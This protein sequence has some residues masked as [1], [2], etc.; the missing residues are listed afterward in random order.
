MGEG[1][2]TEPL[3]EPATVVT[4]PP[5]HML[6]GTCGRSWCENPIMHFLLRPTFALAKVG[7]SNQHLPTAAVQAVA[8]VGY[9]TKGGP[10]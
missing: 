5:T 9:G 4:P 3:R 6:N 7:K 2:V 1:A 8:S 10:K